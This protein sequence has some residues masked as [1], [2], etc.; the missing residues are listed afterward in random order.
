[1]KKKIDRLTCMCQS[2]WNIAICILPLFGLFFAVSSRRWAKSLK[3]YYYKRYSSGHEIDN[4]CFQEIQA[5]ET[6]LI[7]FSYILL[8]QHFSSF[9]SGISCSSLLKNI[10]GPD[11]DSA[12]RPGYYEGT[13]PWRGKCSDV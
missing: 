7:F 6:T 5:P 3:L 12:L 4:S 8:S 9:I 1:M 13:W 2:P 10:V 11:Y